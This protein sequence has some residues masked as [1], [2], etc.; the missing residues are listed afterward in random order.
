MKFG[1]LFSK[2]IVAHPEFNN[3]SANRV[4]KLTYKEMR[5]IAKTL[6]PT[7]K[8]ILNKYFMVSKD[9]L[10]NMVYKALLNL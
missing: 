1:K 5:A 8:E 2:L 7:N 4:S 9:K 3:L 10:A 6:Y